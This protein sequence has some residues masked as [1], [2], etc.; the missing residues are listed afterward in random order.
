MELL[1]ITAILV[2]GV[3]TLLWA[4]V[5]LIRYAT[6]RRDRDRPRPTAGRVHRSRVAVLIAARNE[7]P[8][9]ASTLRSAC[10]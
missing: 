5:G 10:R 1:L 9:I 7:E 3:N 2:V 4:T 6:S 8:V